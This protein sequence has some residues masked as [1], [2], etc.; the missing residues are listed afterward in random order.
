MSN[1]KDE[2]GIPIAFK[3]RKL[4]PFD[5]FRSFSSLQSP[6]LEEKLKKYM[7]EDKLGSLMAGL[8]DVIMI[9]NSRDMLTL[10]TFNKSKVRG[11][12]FN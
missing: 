10:T 6:A 7:I 9:K 2:L 3:Y 5:K 11:Y 12:G 1:A 8:T 4:D